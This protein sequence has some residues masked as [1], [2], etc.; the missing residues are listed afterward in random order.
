MSEG[1]HR[2]PVH[3]RKAEQ[4]KTKEEQSCHSNLCRQN[5]VAVGATTPRV[6]VVG[7]GPAA[8]AASRPY[9]P[10]RADPTTRSAPSPTT[11][12]QS[13]RPLPATAL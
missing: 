10:P 6:G 4:A 2:I 3:G 7:G 1:P 5:I 12:S 9:R 8:G 13:R 11:P